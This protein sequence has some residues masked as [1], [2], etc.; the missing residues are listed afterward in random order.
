MRF[1]L[2]GPVEVIGEDG[3]ALALAGGRERV[4]LATL[5]LGA[6]RPVSVTRLIDALWGDDPPATAANALQVYVSKLRKKLA[7][8][9]VLVESTEGAYLLRT[10][11][12]DVDVACFEELVGSASG[13]PSEA[14][15]RLAEALGLWRGPAL[16]D[17]DSDLLAGERTR[18]EEL[19][20]LALER[21][22]EAELALG[23][24]SDVIA[25]LEALVHAEPLREGPRRQLMV[26][27]YRAG[28][29]ADA[30]ATYRDARE[31][32]AEELGV[33][34]GPELQALEVAILRQDPELEVPHA[35]EV[36]SSREGL[37]TGTVTLL[38]SDIEGSTRLWEKHPEEMATAL[39]RHDEL[40]RRAIKRNRGYV[41]KTMGDA[42]HAAFRTAGEAAAAAIEIQHL[43]ASESWPAPTELR[44]RVA[45]H[46]G[47]CVERDGDY[48]GPAVNRVARLV[49]IG[50]GDQVL[51]SG[52]TAELLEDAPE[53]AVALRDLG[54]H[55][56]KDLGRPERVFQLIVPDLQ[57]D[58]PP[59]HSLD[60]PELTNNLPVQLTSFVGRQRESWDVATLIESHRLVTLTGPG[61]AGKTRLALAVGARL[62]DNF[63]HGVWFVDLASL[64]DSTGVSAE[65][66]SALGL[67]DE[68]GHPIEETLL[69]ALSQRHALIVL[70]NCEHLVDAC[71]RLVDT[72]LRSCS[73]VRVLATSR[74]TLGLSGECHYRVPAL[75]LPAAGEELVR[76]SEAVSLFVERARD[77]GHALDLDQQTDRTVAELCRRLDGMPLAIELACARLRT[78]ALDD[79]VDRL[80]QRLRLLT[81]GNRALPRQQTLRAVIDWSYDMLAE[82]EQIVFERLSV[83]PGDFDLAAAEAVGAEET[84]D[85]S[86]IAETLAS[87]VEKSLVNTSGGPLGL[88]YRFLETLRHY[89]AERLDERHPDATVAATLAHARYFLALAEEGAPHLRGH[90]QAEWLDHFDVEHDNLRIA[91]ERLLR[92]PGVDDEC[93]RFAVSLADF[94]QIRHLAEGVECL[95]AVLARVDS[96]HDLPLRAAILGALG[97]FYEVPEARASL[98]EALEIATRLDLS[99][100]RAELLLSLA[101]FAWEDRKFA[102]FDT[103]TRQALELAES[104]GMARLIARAHQLRSFLMTDFGTAT[105]RSEARRH[106]QAAV[107]CSRVDGDQS[108]EARALGNLACLEL[109]EG[110]YDTAREGWQSV[111]TIAVALRDERASVI[112]LEQLALTEVLQENT[113]EARMHLEEA[114]RL[115]ERIGI[116][117]LMP[118]LLLVFGLC[119]S[120]EEHEEAAVL[121]F[122]ASDQ[123]YE[124]LGTTCQLGEDVLR[125]GALDRLRK[126]MG[127]GF[128]DTYQRGRLL[129]PA[130]A[131]T[132]VTGLR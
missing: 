22:I 37:P 124:D 68:P 9:G 53:R 64:R 77:Q 114:L 46:T 59:L 2:L 78:M 15:A 38:M 116:R 26:A 126:K 8:A 122:G 90:R 41:V 98:D 32:L 51:L 86:E 10:G 130:E 19:R 104:T 18:L 106:L 35:P 48:Y 74:Q 61:G 47:Q 60:N 131:S 119:L 21:R 99:D 91:L 33:D 39:R 127:E 89:G 72:L 117:S 69:A 54:T 85:V 92:M 44:V 45:I 71:M 63:G 118:A 75:S 83:F 107:H 34:P 57:A 7:R 20:L 105:E 14:A 43:V 108:E 76:S 55:R 50:H 12:A 67:R 95:Q 80:D 109:Y 24:H 70:D 23:R 129:S 120:E 4:L 111:V 25:E 65:V 49:A 101:W 93:M 40:L 56:L 1:R 123:L 79:I 115:V 5:V 97:R 30:L 125:R 11:P 121:V 66:A 94:W 82:P 58:F 96:T 52:T 73:E 103:I 132:V 81:G 16:A 42:F 6:N 31:V 13:A 27:L 29:Q 102:E 112:G 110:N 3:Q 36:A 84:S 17:V 100:L 128:D 113:V 28:R 88:R 62:I 87:L